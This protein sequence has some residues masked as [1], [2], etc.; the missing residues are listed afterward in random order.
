M[1]AKALT[2]R[3][4]FDGRV[5]YEIPAF[6]RPYVWTEEDQ[7]QPLWD[8]IQRVTEAHLEADDVGDNTQP[9]PGHFLGAVVLKQRES[10][11]GEPS[12]W[13]VIDGQQR[14]TTLQLLLGAA[15]LVVAEYG[16]EDDAETLMELVGNGSRRFA[17]TEKRFKLWP[18]RVDRGPFACAMDHDV[19]VPAE[20]EE[21]RIVQ[22]HRFFQRAIEEWA[23]G[24]GEDEARATL[25][26]STLTQILSQSLQ[27]VAISLGVHDD[28]QLIF[29][30]L[31]D[32]GTP[33]L[34]ADLI[35]NFV[36]DR[37]EAIGADVERWTDDE[38]ALVAPTGKDA[39]LG[40]RSLLSRYS[41]LV[42]N[43]DIVDHHADEWTDEDVRQRSERLAQAVTEVWPR[44]EAE[45]PAS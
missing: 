8:D 24:S 13:A 42:L 22:A 3:D 9:V 31:N 40:K 15:Q 17:G 1:D 29:E 11:A 10:A 18:S 33:L 6:Q 27:I 21:S 20:L 28:D 38:A 19:A 41:V 32:R 34:A 12:R 36:F 39:G 5:I 26:L 25:R 16:D 2:P 37:C 14:L 43:K 44:M 7:W 35:K 30:T 23:A 45:V 4:L